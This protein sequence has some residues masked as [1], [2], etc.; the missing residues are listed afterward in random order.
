M[1]QH[2][3][4][5][6]SLLP[7]L[8]AFACVARHAS[9]SQ[10]AIELGMSASAASQSVRTLERRLG[11]RLLHRTTRRVGLTEPGERLLREA[12]PALAR[13]GGALQA[14]EE[15][16]DVPAG[17]LRIT[18]PRI[19]VEQMLLPH[20]PAFS[21]RFPHVE[22]ELAVQTALTDLVA[23]GF[24]AGIRLG[25]SLADG[26]VAVPLGPP[27]RL[28]VV[29]A[30]DYLRRHRPPDTPQALATHACIRY[31]RSDGR[32]MPWE[33]SRDGHDFSVEVGGGPIFNDSGLGR[34]MAI[35]GLGL[36]QVFEAAEDL[37]AGRLLRV[38]DAWQPP[39]PGFHL[40]YPSR[41]QLAPKLRVFVDF[42]RDANAPP[43]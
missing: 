3:T 32:L 4:I 14:L 36:A 18:A 11:V 34:R 16:R 31:R 40:Y 9:F 39:F 43:R 21:M 29:A 35:A 8:A 27:Q 41:E 15:S 26:M 13:I 7:A 2:F 38:L 30:P 19:V 10:A 42:M 28:V 20:L 6:P 22:V 12:A 25:E 5:V 37:A 23:E 33:F 24:D 1:K 17:R